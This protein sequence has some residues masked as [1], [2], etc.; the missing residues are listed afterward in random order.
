MNLRDLVLFNLA[1]LIGLTWVAT[2]A[3]AGPSALTLWLL[4]ALLFFVPQGLAVVEL[5]SHFPEEGGVYAWTKREFGEAHGFLCGWCYW[6]NNVLFY[7]SVLFSIASLTAYAIDPGG[8]LND[9][10]TFVLPFTLIIWGRRH[11]QRRRRRP[12]QVA[13]ELRGASTYVAGP[14]SS[15]SASTASSPRSRPTPSPSNPCARVSRTCPRSTSGRPSPSP[16]PA[17]NC[18]RRWAARSRSR[19]ATSRSRSTSPRRSPPCS[20]SS[21]RARCCGICRPVRS[22]SSRRRFRRLRS[23]RAD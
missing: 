13:P 9:R 22:R 1:A 17:L 4:A 2:A 5:S 8:D 3:K 7:P 23:G 16:T 15:P 20:T 14:S 10:W 18:P 12:R 11:P 6:I 19:A 21:A